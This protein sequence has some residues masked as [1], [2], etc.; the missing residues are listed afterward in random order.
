MKVVLTIV[1]AISNSIF[2]FAL[3]GPPFEVIGGAKLIVSFNVED[4]AASVKGKLSSGDE[5]IISA[6]Q[7]T[8][9]I[10]AIHHKM[11]KE[12]LAIE[13]Y[14]AQSLLISVYEYDFDKDGEMELIV[15]D[16]PDYSI[17]NIHIFRYSNGLTELVGNLFGQFL[18]SLEDNVISLPFGSQGLTD[19]Y[20]Y[21]SG[22][23]YN[24]VYHDPENRD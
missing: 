1:L 3:D 4:E 17:V 12:L 11:G 15:V 22:A 5:I 13:D 20:I 14:E 16:S 9:S 19:E 21:R 23:F 2:S 7:N 18:I 24:L 8:L 6:R 10:Q